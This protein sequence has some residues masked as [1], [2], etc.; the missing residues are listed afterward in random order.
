MTA[1]F[2]KLPSSPVSEAQRTA[3]PDVDLNACAAA[4]AYEMATMT[5]EKFCRFV[6]ESEASETVNDWWDT[7]NLATAALADYAAMVM[8][9]VK[10]LDA[11]GLIERHPNMPNWIA[12]L[13]ES[14]ASR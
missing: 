3:I 12:L 9:G 4:L 13:D 2:D 14:E 1:L 10:Y 6:G 8:D 7:S 5:V 11:R